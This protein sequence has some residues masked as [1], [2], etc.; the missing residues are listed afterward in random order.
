MTLHLAEHSRGA[1]RQVRDVVFVDLV[2]EIAV[3]QIFLDE[4]RAF[5]HPAFD[6]ILPTQRSRWRKFKPGF[7]GWRR[8]RCQTGCGNGYRVFRCRVEDV[9]LAGVL[10]VVLLSVDA[11]FAGHDVVGNVLPLRIVCG[12]TKIL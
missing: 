7:V 6:R 4:L 3:R 5:G 12:G 11:A 9:L 10:D 8:P 1:E 2:V